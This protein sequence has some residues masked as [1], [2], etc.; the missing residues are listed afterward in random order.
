VHPTFY[1]CR[2]ELVSRDLVAGAH[3]YL[4]PGAS[5]CPKVCLGKY[6]MVAPHCAILGGDHRYDLPGVPMI[7]SGRPEV[8]PTIIED[9]VWVG[10]R[11]TIM[12]GVRIGKGAIVAAGAVVTKDVE[13]YS[14]VAGVPAKPVARRFADEKQIA[15]HD[16]ML[17]RPPRRGQYAS[18]K[19]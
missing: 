10:Y 13:P 16:R 3:S 1:V 5:I 12:A 15:E 18:A 8:P 14:I 6:V 7:F 4:G 11:C 2:P 17:S 19:T 9:D